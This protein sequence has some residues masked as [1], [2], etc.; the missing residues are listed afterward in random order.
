MLHAESFWSTAQCLTTTYAILDAS[1][2]KP[3]AEAQGFPRLLN[4]PQL[5]NAPFDGATSLEL[6]LDLATSMVRAF[7]RQ[8]CNS[9]QRI[10][11]FPCA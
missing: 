10:E 7:T 8:P 11:S 5:H 4:P 3:A 1:L 2:G 9:F 6:T